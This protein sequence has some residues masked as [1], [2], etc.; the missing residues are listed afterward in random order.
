MAKINNRFKELDGLRAFAILLVV[1][2]HLSSYLTTNLYGLKS[3]F[4]TGHNGV[5]LFFVLSGFLVGRLAFLEIEKENHLN[6]FRFWGKRFLRTWPLYFIFL[7]YYLLKTDYEVIPKV[8]RYL[9]FTQNLSEM[10][11]FVQ[12]WS[13]AVEEQ[14]YFLLPVLLSLFIKLKSKKP[15]FIFA[16]SLFISSY[17]FRYYNLNTSHTLASLDTL[18]LGILISYF[19]VFEKNKLKA[20]KSKPYLLMILGIISIYL[21]YMVNLTEEWTR[22]FRYGFQSIGFTLLLISA[23]SDKRTLLS[24]FLSSKVLYYIA[25]FSYSIYLSHSIIIFKI[26]RVYFSSM[27]NLILKDIII[28]LL[29]TAGSIFAGGISYYLIEKPLLKARDYFVK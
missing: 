17:I 21:F 3:F 25:I 14:F 2:Y 24:H 15:L 26:G 29:G 16:L 27:N 7:I 20:L 12:S 13:L 10:N 11:T 19:E 28:L 8:W 23:L 5:D 22:V 1:F 9:T 4:L 6:I 18:I